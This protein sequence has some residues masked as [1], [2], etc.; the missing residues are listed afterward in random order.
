MRKRKRILRNVGMGIMGLGLLGA[1]AFGIS[2]LVEYINSDLT[3]IHLNYEVGGLDSATGIYEDNDDTIYTKE[4]FPCWGLQAK[5]DF[6][7]QITYQ[8]FYYDILDNFISS[9]DI[10][11]SGYSGE[12]PINGAYARIEITPTDFT[13]DDTTISWYEVGGYSKQL[14]LK[15]FKEQ[16]INERFVS[17]RGRNL[18]VVDNI[19]DSLFE[20]GVGINKDNYDWT[21]TNHCSC[22]TSTILKIDNSVKV[23][24][25]N[26]KL[27]SF[28]SSA[29]LR[30]FELDD[31]LNV[32]KH[33]EL[34]VSDNSIPFTSSKNTS[35]L[36]FSFYF[37]EEADLTTCFTSLLNCI[38]VIN[39]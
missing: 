9:T 35:Y 15:T 10:L 7:A 32:L 38:S 2:K 39:V 22:T 18:Q 27:P 21:N 33:N 26:S 24:V 12:A 29:Y 1:G 28:V 8:V 19:S 37:V 30:V 20:K 36:L 31:S 25:I 16:K 14:N 3:T 23:S 34:F 11:T 5:L 17:Y 6:D 13:K 4:A